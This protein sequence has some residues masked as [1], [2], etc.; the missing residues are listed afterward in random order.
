ME[1]YVEFVADQLLRSMGYKAWFHTPNPVSVGTSVS[2]SLANVDEQ[3]P[4]MAM[5]SMPSR[6]NFFERKN[7]DYRMLSGGDIDLTREDL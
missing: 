2:P 4:F 5:V 3:L 7:A 1:S 6:T